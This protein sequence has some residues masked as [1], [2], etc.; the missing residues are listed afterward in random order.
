MCITNIKTCPVILLMNKFTLFWH[1]FHNSIRVFFFLFFFAHESFL[2]ICMWPIDWTLNDA[3]YPVQKVFGSNG[4][5]DIF[6][7]RHISKTGISAQTQ[8]RVI[9]KIH[10]LRVTG[11]VSGYPTGDTNSVFCSSLTWHLILR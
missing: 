9:L 8:F 5:R 11:G 10:L 3:T 7:S 2:N 4:N 6:H 1:H